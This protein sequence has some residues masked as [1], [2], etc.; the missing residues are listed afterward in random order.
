[1]G[2]DLDS[3][4]LENGNPVLHIP[5]I[6]FP[7]RG[8]LSFSYSLYHNGKNV[9]LQRL[10]LPPDLNN[11]SG[12]SVKLVSDQYMGVTSRTYQI[13]P[14]SQITLYYAAAA[15]GTQ[16]LL[17][18][19]NGAYESIDATG[20]NGNPTTF[21]LIDRS[22]IRYWNVG[23]GPSV[24][25]GTKLI[26]DV[27]G[28][29]ISFN[30][31]TNTYE[32]S[33][34]RTLPAAETPAGTGGCPSGTLPN[35][36]ATVMN[37][38]VYTGTAGANGTTAPY[39]LCYAKVSVAIA[40]GTHGSA[41]PFA[42]TATVL[43]S[44]VLPNGKYW[45]FEYNDLDDAGDSYGSLSRIVLP[46]GGS[47]S[48]TYTTCSGGQFG[49]ASR[50]VASRTISDGTH[51]HQ[52]TYSYGAGTTT[53]YDPDGNYSVHSFSSLD[54]GNTFYEVKAQYYDSS[55]TL[56]KTIDTSYNYR[57]SILYCRYNGS[58]AENVVPHTIATT[59][60]DT[61][62]VST[63]TKTYDSGFPVTYR[64]QQH[65]LLRLGGG[66][67]HHRLRRFNATSPCR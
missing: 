48:Y 57:T 9:S 50:C 31:N 59:L 5:L 29:Y 66:R 30:T 60:N 67:D 43:Q 22:G 25:T 62:Q 42:F 52:W 51:S 38:P 16:H 23:T 19:A 26:E 55:T 4:N 33:V 1:M 11:S 2:G 58:C 14:T 32:D 20:I 34:G 49:L 56:L 3:M 46:I 47:I 28:N 54:Q 63:V 39:L 41:D 13:T 15:D 35:T 18:P 8:R 65:I 64:R 53:V 44:V 45:Q 12:Y 40:E 21:Q 36:S 24:P 61:G 10:C 7:Q 17:E 27:N 37:F 6:D